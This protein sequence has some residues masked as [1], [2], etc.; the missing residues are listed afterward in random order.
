MTQI[1][2]FAL[3]GRLLVFLFQ[4]FPKNKLPFIGTL[5][6]EGKFLEQLF[7]CDLCLGFWVYVGLSFI[8][9]VNVA[10]EWVYIPVFSEFVTGAVVSFVMH[11]ISAGW[12]S[13]YK[14][15]IIE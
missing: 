13:Q 15:I 9:N 8:T 5:F 1:V 14:N 12:E 10:E 11:L 4:K 2:I 7:S 6:G 3:I